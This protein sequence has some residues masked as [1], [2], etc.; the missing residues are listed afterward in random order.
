MNNF[1]TEDF[2]ARQNRLCNREH[3]FFEICVQKEKNETEN[4]HEVIVILA[5]GFLVRL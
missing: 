3:E 4:K 2:P 5:L 1:A